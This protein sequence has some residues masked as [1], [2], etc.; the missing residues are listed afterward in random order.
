MTEPEQLY[1]FVQPRA[2]AALVPE[3]ASCTETEV[4]YYLRVREAD[5][6]VLIRVLK[7]SLDV[8]NVSKESLNE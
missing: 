3:G 7:G 6:Y 4:A 8:T 5:K 1:V 2:E